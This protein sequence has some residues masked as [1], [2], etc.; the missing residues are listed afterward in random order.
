VRAQLSRRTYADLPATK[1]HSHPTLEALRLAIGYARP[2]GS[3]R[4][5]DR[6]APLGPLQLGK[7]LDRRVAATIDE[8]VQSVLG[9]EGAAVSSFRR[10]RDFELQ[11]VLELPFAHY[12]YARR[13]MSEELER[14]PQFASTSTQIRDPQW[15]D[16]SRDE[17]IRLASVIRVPSQQ[18]LD[19]LP[20]AAA[21]AE[22]EFAPYGCPPVTYDRI[23]A[24]RVNEPLRALFVG[25]LQSDKG[26][27]Y[28]DQ[29]IET[30]GEKIQWTVIGYRPFA[31]SKA[32]D[33]MLSR[34]SYL[35]TMPR[36]L[37]LT[38][39]RNAHVL[40]LPSLVE[41]RSLAALEALSSGLPIIVTPGTGVED[42]FDAYTPGFLA[43]PAS[44]DDLESSLSTLLDDPSELQYR[45]G[46]AFNAAKAHPWEKYRQVVAQRALRGQAE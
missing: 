37:V 43:R 14:N 3:R 42:I 21:L 12:S 17:E 15:F 31:Q 27:A 19:N 41:G 11:T 46:E 34:V 8:S 29:A 24:R 22:I 16:D 33:R 39:M 10:A 6:Q 13:V 4:L 9:W 40:I 26:I 30:F 28:L 38:K 20:P 35:G 44:H 1:V 32:L 45:S 5:V 36:D 2:P 7:H 18:V 25:R 23:R